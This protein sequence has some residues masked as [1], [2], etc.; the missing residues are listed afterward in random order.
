MPR[1]GRGTRDRLLTVAEQLVLEYG[2]AGAS[3]DRIVSAAGVTRGAFF[4]HFDAKADLL[5]S[6]L[7]RY[8]SAD[9]DQL[10]AAMRRAE[11]LSRDP[12]QQVLIFVGFFLEAAERLKEPHPGGLYGAC[13][14]A[15]ALLEPSSRLTL[16]EAFRTWRARLS[17][18]LREVGRV[19]TP[20]QEV[21]YDSL[22]EQM[23]VM[24]EGAF[25]VG[26]GVAEARV[27]AS[28]L[29]QYRQHLELLFAPDDYLQST[30]G[31]AT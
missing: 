22:A 6:L 2:Y 1:D 12:L 5:R 13:C 8:W 7:E 19:Y 30:S 4:H 10:E 29:R 17:T 20:R 27:V 28:Q 31:R 25:V 26:K 16:A 15:Q 3:V 11:N 23:N 9:L 24:L 21:D 14:Y 18:K